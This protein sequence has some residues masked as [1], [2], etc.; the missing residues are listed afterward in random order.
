MRILREAPFTWTLGKGFFS[1]VQMVKT[2]REVD[3]FER[4]VGLS[5]L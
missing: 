1:Q 3:L 2:V 5:R 4:E